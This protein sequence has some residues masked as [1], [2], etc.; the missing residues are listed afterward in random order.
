MSQD[1]AKDVGTQWRLE[2]ED[3]RGLFSL[4]DP[5]A[6]LRIEIAKFSPALES[7]V[8]ERIQVLLDREGSYLVDAH[9]LLAVSLD[10]ILHERVRGLEDTAGREEPDSDSDFAIEPLRS[11][12]FPDG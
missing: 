7:K 1:T 10:E 3:T 12:L 4:L 2:N 9:V 8:I 6:R 11:N 5:P